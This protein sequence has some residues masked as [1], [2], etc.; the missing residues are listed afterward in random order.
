MSDIA[1][2]HIP[3]RARTTRMVLLGATL[4]ALAATIV[5]LALSSGASENAGAGVTPVSQTSGPDETQRG[6]A[7]A[8]SAGADQPTT[9]GPDESARGISVAAASGS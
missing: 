2:T 9:G 4:L 8:S 3:F 6:Q 5:V 7:A 1:H